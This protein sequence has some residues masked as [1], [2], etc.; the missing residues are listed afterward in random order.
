[1]A[2]PATDLSAD[3]LSPTSALLEWTPPSSG[4]EVTGFTVYVQSGLLTVQELNVS[5]GDSMRAILENLVLKSYTVQ[6]FSRSGFFHS[7]PVT[8]QLVFSGEYWVWGC[9]VSL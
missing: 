8:L 4:P 9:E 7:V 1:M 3:L 6:V 5:D 2:L